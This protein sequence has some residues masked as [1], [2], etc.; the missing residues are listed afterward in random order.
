MLLSFKM[1]LKVLDPYREQREAAR[2]RADFLRRHLGRALV[3]NEYEQLL[4]AQARRARRS[5]WPYPPL[6]SFLSLLL[7]CARRPAA[8]PPFA[9][10]GASFLPPHS[11]SARPQTPQ[12][13]RHRS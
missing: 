12:N 8:P 4:A 3:L 2:K 13:P 9:G 7:R 11:I 6:S 5:S 10:G 1:M